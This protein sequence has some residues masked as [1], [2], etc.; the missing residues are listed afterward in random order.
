MKGNTSEA[1]KSVCVFEENAPAVERFKIDFSASI[2][3]GGGLR[4]RV[5]ELREFYDPQC[6]AYFEQILSKRKEAFCDSAS[7]FMLL[8]SLLQKNK[9]DRYKTAI[10]LDD[11][12]RPYIDDPGL[13]FS[14]SHSEGCAI[15]VLAMG[16]DAAV[17]CDVQRARLYSDEK[18][19]ELAAAF[20]T[21]DEFSEFSKTAEKSV[22]FFTK[23][24]RREAYVKRVGSDIF[25]NLKT[26]D[27]SGE[28]FRDG[29]ITACGE[30]YY[31]SINTLPPEISDDPE[32]E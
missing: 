10:L 5:E 18:L 29:V 22:F 3:T 16:E 6:A 1:G 15:C 20:M 21:A 7:A 25:D 8:D 30:R 24:T 4:Q 12:G 26:A 14:V 32:N 19:T 2:V 23:W 13:D 28:Y 9:I 17:G 31:F 11:F 27:L